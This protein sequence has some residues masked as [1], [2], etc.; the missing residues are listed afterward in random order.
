MI[1]IKSAR[2]NVVQVLLENGADLNVRDRLGNT[3]LHHAAFQGMATI[4]RLLVKKEVYVNEIGHY[5]RTALHV[6]A[7][8]G[9]E[10]VVKILKEAGANL[11]M[12]DEE[13]KTALKLAEEKR[14]GPQA[15]EEVAQQEEPVHSKLRRKTKESRLP[16]TFIPQTR[17]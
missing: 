8:R 4:V 9:N 13:K 17:L 16:T 7:Q 15:E 3:A 12:T 5:G 10:V 2:L 1:A 6:A 14:Q 11:K